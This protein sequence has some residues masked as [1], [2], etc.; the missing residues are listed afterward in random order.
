MAE[1]VG[2]ADQYMIMI[3]VTLLFTILALIYEKKLTFGLLA[4]IAWFVS[5][6]G[7]LAVG[8]KTSVLTAALPLIFFIFGFLFSLKVTL[9]ALSMFKEKRTWR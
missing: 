4:A 3:A 7:H 6:L 1:V 2:V 8:D 5:S 9:Q